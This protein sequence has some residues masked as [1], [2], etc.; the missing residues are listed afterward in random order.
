[1]ALPYIGFSIYYQWKVARQWC[2]LCLQV[3]GLLFS[4]FITAFIGGFHIALP[5]QQIPPQA[6]MII[7]GAFILLFALL[8]LLMPALEKA[9][10]GR[11]RKTDLARLKHNPQVFE[12]LLGRQKT[13]EKPAD[14]L[15]ITIGNPDGVYK[16]IKVCNPYCGPCASAHPAM[17]ELVH[18]NEEVCL[19]V[20]FTATDDDAD[21]KKW[22]V[23]HLL[24]I[25]TKNDKALTQKALD[26]WYNAPVKDYAVFA[27]KYPLNGELQQQ[28]KKIKEMREWCD[29]I[30]LAYTPTFFICLNMANNEKKFYQLPDFYTVDD[31]RYFFTI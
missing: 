3:Q 27:N 21:M 6:Y 12:A 15:G 9:K 18:N 4:Q 1:L 2:L 29:K 28:N 31:L 13:I 14:N 20:I 7:A 26:D 16:L 5:L 22:P 11:Q 23:S 8:L 19:Q 25:D 17:E 24:A 10:E 30:G